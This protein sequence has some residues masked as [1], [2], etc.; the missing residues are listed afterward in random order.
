MKPSAPPPQNWNNLGDTLD[1]TTGRIV[2]QENEIAEMK[3]EPQEAQSIPRTADQQLDDEL[4]G[5]EE[6]DH[7]SDSSNSQDSRPN[8][9]DDIFFETNSLSRFRI[10]TGTDFPNAK[11]AASREHFKDFVL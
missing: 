5:T 3:E 6:N 10:L 8:R 2:Q 4:H 9:D 1:I 7:K 11:F